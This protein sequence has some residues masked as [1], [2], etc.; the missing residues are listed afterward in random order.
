MTKLKTFLSKVHC[1]KDKY[2]LFRI[3]VSFSLATQRGDD[4]GH[5]KTKITGG[6]QKIGQIAENRFLQPGVF[7]G[8]CYSSSIDYWLMK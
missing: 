5:S 6:A 3:L 7:M 4:L 2:V 1:S 8:S